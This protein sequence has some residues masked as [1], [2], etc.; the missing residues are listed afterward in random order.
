M[1]SEGT[2]IRRVI[3]VFLF[4]L[5]L[6]T[7][8]AA[9]EMCGEQG[10]WVQGNCMQLFKFTIHSTLPPYIFRVN[11]R[12][13]GEYGGIIEFVQIEVMKG[14]NPTVLQTLVVDDISAPSLDFLAVDM[15]FDG[16]SDLKLL[17]TAGATGN[18]AYKV[19]LFKPAG[20]TFI[21]APDLRPT[22]HG[23]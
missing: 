13:T 7:D 18:A 15:N 17:W 22:G 19:W 3:L 21:H 11:W 6:T 23:D 12:P 4:P 5:L 9:Q 14:E 2:K 8:S 10:K 16:Y 1:I 20:Q